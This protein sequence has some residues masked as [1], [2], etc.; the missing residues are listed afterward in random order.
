[1][2]ILSCYYCGQQFSSEYSEEEL[3]EAAILE[4]DLPE[5]NLEIRDVCETYYEGVI[6]KQH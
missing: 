2:V 4:F 5:A 3:R 6:G 1:M